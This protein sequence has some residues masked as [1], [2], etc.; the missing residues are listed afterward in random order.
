MEAEEETEDQVMSEIHLGCPPDAKSHFTRFTISPSSLSSPNR[1]TG[2]FEPYP[3]CNL[4][5]NVEAS[6]CQQYIID[7]E[8]DLVLARRNHNRHNVRGANDSILVHHHI[9]TAIPRVGL[10][11]WR[12]SLVLSDFVLH[13]INTST[14]FN[15][16]VALELGAGTG[17]VG[18]LLARAA[19]TVFIT[20]KGKD[21]L[22]NCFG[23]VELNLHSYKH[24]EKSI[25]VRHLDW[26]D[27]WPPKE[28][29]TEELLTSYKYK[30][31]WTSSDIEEAEAASILVAADVVYSDEVTDAF[32]KI[33]RE[34]M[35]LGSKKVL[36]LS[37]EK[38]YNFTMEDLD[39]VAHGY[40][41]FRTFFAEEVPE[42]TTTAC[43]RYQ[44]PQRES[45]MTGPHFIGKRLDTASI[46]QYIKEYDRGGDTELWEIR[47]QGRE[48]I[49]GRI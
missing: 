49:T 32:F 35:P 13:S 36:L 24:N 41:H 40:Q 33:L 2:G 12:A 21:I 30:Y 16:V 25:R 22:E 26:Q 47:A 8:G 39:V 37:L 18:I 10:Q 38:R 5:H 46:P 27:L 6:T 29:Q 11:I 48:S 1:L 15:N 20:D 17:M 19:H 42:C 23:N 4:F 44:P 43:A 14:Y 31:S 28:I 34:L 45:G 9:T 7:K 3:I